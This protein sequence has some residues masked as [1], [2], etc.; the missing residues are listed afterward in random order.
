[1][2]Q[3]GGGRR[4]QQRRAQE[5]EGVGWQGRNARREDHGEGRDE[6]EYDPLEVGNRGYQQRVEEERQDH[7]EETEEK[8]DKVARLLPGTLPVGELRKRYKIMSRKSVYKKLETDVAKGAAIGGPR[9]KRIQ[10]YS[11][12]LNRAP[13]TGLR[14]SNNDVQNKCVQIRIE[15]CS[16]GHHR[17][18]SRREDFR[19]CGTRAGGGLRRPPPWPA[20]SSSVSEQNV[21]N[22]L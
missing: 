19:V 6:H 7:K 12:T 21:K 15:A 3:D 16:T 18:F 17:G 5:G 11:R 10:H 1:M 14:S 9:G 2:L 22:L 4:R 8:G 20:P 13:V